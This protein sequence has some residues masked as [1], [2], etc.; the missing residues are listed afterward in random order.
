MKKHNAPHGKSRHKKLRKRNI[1]LKHNNIYIN[2][3]GQ[4]K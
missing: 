4:L 1:E 2:E 3:R